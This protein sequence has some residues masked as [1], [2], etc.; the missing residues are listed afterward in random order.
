MPHIEVVLLLLL[1]AVGLLER[2]SVNII[3][4]LVS[5]H[6][7]VLHSIIQATI[8]SCLHLFLY[9][10]IRLRKGSAV[11]ETATGHSS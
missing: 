9:Q 1:L 2:V 3:D 4:V 5:C 6:V 8:L 10:I 7:R 11:T